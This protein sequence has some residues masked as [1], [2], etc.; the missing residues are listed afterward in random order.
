MVNLKKTNVAVMTEATS[1]DGNLET[2]MGSSAPKELEPSS[3]DRIKPDKK[4]KVGSEKSSTE[5]TMEK[6]METIKTLFEEQK[7]LRSEL[8]KLQAGSFIPQT[9]KKPE[10]ITHLNVSGET[11]TIIGTNPS[12]TLRD[13]FFRDIMASYESQSFFN[14]NYTHAINTLYE[15]SPSMFTEDVLKIILIFDDNR[16]FTISDIGKLSKLMELDAFR[17]YAN[18][19]PDNSS[20]YENTIEIF[21]NFILNNKVLTTSVQR[22]KTNIC[23]L[24]KSTLQVTNRN[25]TLN[26][27]SA[28]AKSTFKPSQPKIS[29]T[30]EKNRLITKVLA[31]VAESSSKETFTYMP[32]FSSV[33]YYSIPQRTV[34]C[35]SILALSKIIERGHQAVQASFTPYLSASLYSDSGSTIEIQ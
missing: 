4:A 6:Y 12:K 34:L 16:D 13:K 21:L 15:T 19:K 2:K 9:V 18:S 31:Q 23:T 26:N 20:I 25:G 11:S 14:V 24:L 5:K 22:I 7:N 1:T 29:N 33:Q 3:M 30:E 10:E 35:S 8:K 28:Y 17:N 27:A 32:G